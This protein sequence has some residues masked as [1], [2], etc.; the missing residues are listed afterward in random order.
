MRDGEGSHYQRRRQGNEMAGG[1]C[2]C[3]QYLGARTVLERAT[4]EQGC[5]EV[6]CSRSFG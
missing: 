3:Q 6:V 4:A 1:C 2:P 5:D